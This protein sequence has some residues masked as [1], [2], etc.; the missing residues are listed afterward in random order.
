M[1]WPHHKEANGE[2]VGFRVWLPGCTM[3]RDEDVEVEQQ[4]LKPLAT[5]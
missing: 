1:T 4:E 5:T 2:G 3:H